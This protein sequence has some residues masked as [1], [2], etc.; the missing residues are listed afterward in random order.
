MRNGVVVKDAVP[1]KASSTQQVGQSPLCPDEGNEY[2][3]TRGKFV[4]AD[5]KWYRLIDWFFSEL[6]WP[7]EPNKA[8]VDA[9][10]MRY[11][12]TLLLETIFPEHPKYFVHTFAIREEMRLL[13]SGQFDVPHLQKPYEL[14]PDS[15]VDV[16]GRKWGIEGYAHTTEIVKAD[17]KRLRHEL[18]IEQAARKS[19]QNEAQND[20]D[21]SNNAQ[22]KAVLPGWKSGKLCLKELPNGH[23]PAV[24][25][26]GKETY[27]VPSGKAWEIVS[28]MIEADAYEGHGVKLP[29]R[30]GDAFKKGHRHFYSEIM[31]TASDG[32]RSDKPAFFDDL[33]IEERK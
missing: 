5:G 33:L 7:L 31:K 22:T 24:F 10:F 18:A 6:D 28:G 29:A 4:F 11:S 27:T 23:Q 21:Q 16:D 32:N 1:A 13:P 3:H 12:C 2:V 20:A 17:M 26:F 30:A 19:E 8:G 14:G 15:V 25:G 9:V